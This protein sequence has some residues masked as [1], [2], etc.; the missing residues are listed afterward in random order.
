MAG[1]VTKAEAPV[2]REA[3]RSTAQRRPAQAQSSPAA[4]AEPTARPPDPPGRQLRPT[5]ASL[6]RGRNADRH[7]AALLRRPGVIYSRFPEFGTTGRGLGTFAHA[8]LTDN[9]ADWWQLALAGQVPGTGPIARDLTVRG[10]TAASAFQRQFFSTL[11]TVVGARLGEIGRELQ[12][13]GLNGFVPRARQIPWDTAPA[14]ASVNTVAGTEFYVTV[15][16]HGP[17]TLA[18]VDVAGLLGPMSVVALLTPVVPDGDPATPVFTINFVLPQRAVGLE[19]GFLN[20]PAYD[21]ESFILTA[22]DAAGQPVGM[23]LGSALAANNWGPAQVRFIGMVDQR[24]SIASVELRSTDPGFAAGKRFFT[25]RIW[26][27]CLPPAVMLQGTLCNVPAD[28]FADAQHAEHP[29]VLAFRAENPAARAGTWGPIRQSPLQIDLPYR[30]DKAVV[31][32]RGFKLAHKGASAMHVQRLTAH[33][34]SWFSGTTLNIHF[35]GELAGSPDVSFGTG[36]IGDPGGV[37]PYRGDTLGGGYYMV[38]AWESARVDLHSSPAEPN[39]SHTGNQSTHVFDLPNRHP[40]A[41]D[42]VG[43]AEERMGPLL[44]AVRG[45]RWSCDVAQELQGFAFI[46]GSRGGGD[47]GG[48]VDWDDAGVG[49]E[50]V[51]IPGVSW[52]A[53]A[54]W[55]LIAWGDYSVVEETKPDWN[56]LRMPPLAYTNFG[57]DIRWSFGNDLRDTASDDAVVRSGMSGLVLNGSSLAV[58]FDANNIRFDADT[59]NVAQ[60]KLAATPFHAISVESP[61]ADVQY[62]MAIVGLGPFIMIPEDAVHELDIE[63]RV[64]SFDGHETRM[65]VGGGIDLKPST[66]DARFVFGLPVVGGLRRVTAQPIHR[67]SVRNVL[68]RIPRGQLAL[69]PLEYGALRNDGNVPLLIDSMELT[70]VARDEY[71]LKIDYRGTEIGVWDVA[72]RGPLLLEP[73]ESVIVSGAFYTRPPRPRK[74]GSSNSDS[75]RAAPARLRAHPATLRC[76]TNQPGYDVVEIFARADIVPADAIATVSPQNINF[77]LFHLLRNAAQQQPRQRG[78]IVTSD[79]TTPVSISAIAIQPPSSVFQW[80]VVDA[81]V[82]GS[83][84]AASIYQLDPGTS[85][86]LAVFFNPNMVGVQQATLTIATNAG[87]FQVALRG[88]GAQQ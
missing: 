12:F 55:A 79:G 6:A 61:L 69:A 47:D 86:L 4:K 29:D 31:L 49:I 59:S 18:V 85:I 88:E 14:P 22:R 57:R 43:V 9:R 42:V 23:S 84:G 38:I 36:V 1:K 81:P 66:D 54:G 53:G 65:F 20:D 74:R 13:D 77:G 3:V 72:A 80:H 56:F 63:L 32:M 10:E 58:N 41:Q 44:G 8:Y 46:P 70:G 24:G 15:G 7:A 37:A 78:L 5:D 71:N 83:A 17:C 11:A 21:A 19:C 28:E 34:S 64:D 27:E 2:A 25:T 76:R 35:A 45:W 16:A 82:G 52:L 33:L 62:D 75:G 87:D 51:I 67:I 50:D 60:R 48:R 73:G 30:C 26:Y 40:A 39:E 68:F